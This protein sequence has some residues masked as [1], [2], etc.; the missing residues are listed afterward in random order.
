MA[1]HAAEIPLPDSSCHSV[2]AADAF[3]WFATPESLFEISRVLQVRGYLGFVW[4]DIDCAPRP[5]ASSLYGAQA[6]GG[7]PSVVPLQKL[8]SGTIGTALA[9]SAYPDMDPSLFQSPPYQR[10]EAWMSVFDHFLGCYFGSVHRHEHRYTHHVSQ[11]L[12][13]LVHTD[14]CYHA[15]RILRPCLWCSPPP[16]LADSLLPASSPPPP[17][18]H[19]RAHTHARTHY[20]PPHTPLTPPS[21]PDDRE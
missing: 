7:S 4:T 19:T 13:A 15:P 11:S 8:R 16:R 14:L 17:P 5:S 9:R 6:V 12:H 2:F 1:G 3:H 21:F 10:G 18:T 20:P